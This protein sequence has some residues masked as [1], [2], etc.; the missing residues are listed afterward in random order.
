MD[1]LQQAMGLAVL[2]AVA[3]DAGEDGLGIIAQ[4]RELDQV[5]GIEHHVCIL[6]ERKYPFF[7]RIADV[8][9]LA[10]GLAGRECPFVVVTD[11]AAQQT[12]VAGRYPVMVVQGRT[13]E[14][15]DEDAELAV[16]R[17]AG[18]QA[19][20]E[21]VDAL[22]EKDRV[23][24]EMQALAVILPLSCNEIVFRHFYGLSGEE[25][26]HVALQHVVVDRVEIVEIVAPVGKLGCIYP[27]DEIVVRRE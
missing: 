9:P 8:L 3:R 21:G 27:V 12:V 14:R 24:V 17:D 5:C 16:V 15:G 13:R 23:L 26:H 6:L 20:V 1:E 7:L 18:G 4:Y 10:D 2:R 22:D 25:V 11:D 19:R